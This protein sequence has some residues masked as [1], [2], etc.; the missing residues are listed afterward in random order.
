MRATLSPFS[1]SSSGQRMRSARA[2]RSN[3]EA[4]WSGFRDRYGAPHD[5]PCRPSSA[6]CGSAR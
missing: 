5:P 3:D 6:P 1:A 2:E 4:E